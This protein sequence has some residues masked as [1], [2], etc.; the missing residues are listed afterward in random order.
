MDKLEDLENQFFR[1]IGV[2]KDI[3]SVIID[4]SREFINSKKNELLNQIEISLSEKLDFD[5]MPDNL[6]IIDFLVKGEI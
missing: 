1:E 5:R 2:L 4:E 3:Q 6:R